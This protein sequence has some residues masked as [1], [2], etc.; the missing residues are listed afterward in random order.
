MQAQLARAGIRVFSYR[1]AGSNGVF[2]D[3]E[4]S[5]RGRRAG[6][7]DSERLVA[8]HPQHGLDAIQA[9]VRGRPQTA[10]AARLRPRCRVAARRLR[11]RRRR[12]SPRHAR[13]RRRRECL[14]RRRP[15]VGRSP[16]SR[17]CW[18]ERRRSS[19]KC[20]RRDCSPRRDVPQ[21]KRVWGALASVPAVAAG[22]HP[23]PHGR[24]SGRARVRASSRATEAFAR[25][26]HPDAFK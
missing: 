19:S 15:R 10:D 25:A 9:R 20:A 18:R 1:H 22:P 11:Q 4:G 3:V 5:W 16:R 23:D 24:S 14:R 8:R 12:L 17:R 21:A 13:N 26:L 6:P 7:T 2:D